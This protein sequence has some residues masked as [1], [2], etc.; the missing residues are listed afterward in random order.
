MNHFKQFCHT[1]HSSSS[2]KGQSPFKKGKPQQYRDRRSSGKFKGKSKG[3]SA[4]GGGGGSTPY[5]KKKQH[6]KDKRGVHA[7]TLKENSVLSA[8][9]EA[10][11]D[12]PVQQLS[13]KGKVKNQNS[14]LSGPPKPG[15]SNSFACNAVHSKLNHTHNESNAA[16]SKRLYTD[17]DP[18][19]QTE[20]ITDIQVKKPARAGSL[21]MEVKVDPGSEANCMPLHKF[22][23]LSLSM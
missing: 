7:V 1:R 17:T 4:K 18:T 21:W 16:Q 12:G 6:F 19:S 14:V 11:I 23:S 2:S 20:I 8:P 22:I 15:M 5:K 9:G 3:P 13:R 10:Q